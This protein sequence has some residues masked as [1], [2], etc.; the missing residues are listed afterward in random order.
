MNNS[1]NSDT[2]NYLNNDEINIISI[3]RI[4]LRS[5]KLL[6][7]S[8]FSFT[9]LIVIFSYFI[10]PVWKGSFEME[11]T[12]SINNRNLFNSSNILKS[13]SGGEISSNNKTEELV[14]KSPLVLNDVFQFHKEYLKRK[15]KNNVE[16]NL[17]F[18][19]W[20]RSFE[21]NF[22]RGTNII[23]VSFINTD[24]DHILNV[25]NLI[26]DKYEDYSL[27]DRIE[28]LEKLNDYLISQKKIVK[29]KSSESMRELNKFA[30]KHGLGNIDG[31]VAL[32]SETTAKIPRNL[33]S[34][35][36][37]Q[38]AIKNLTKNF[39][40][41]DKEISA[42]QRYA[43][44]RILLEN[45]EAEY[46]DLLA[47]LKPNASTIINL[48]KKIDNLKSRLKRPNEILIRYRELSAKAKRDEKIFFDV[49]NQLSMLKLDIARSETPWATITPPFLH[50]IRVSP[51]RKSI[52]LTAFFISLVSLSTYIIVKEKISGRIFEFDDLKN[53]LKLNH[54]LSL[55]GE[56][57]KVDINFV[58]TLI[59]NDL[60]KLSNTSYEKEQIKIITTVG[61]DDPYFK[62]VSRE[63]E[64]EIISLDTN[65]IDNADYLILMLNQNITKNEIE[66][67]NNYV[68]IYK[69]KI[70]GWIYLG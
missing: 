37:D 52:A 18:N 55:N 57:L 30:I 67:I 45:Y 11:M 29:V 33:N 8:T 53:R 68:Q 54:R 48:K 59:N 13:L 60:E 69:D 63:I 23:N 4:L 70:F 22:K 50:P 3:F 20:L 62:E 41:N 64:Y 36:F 61:L 14:L 65:K 19:N 6:L 10:K 28:K 16:K 40:S 66:K 42:G 1:S 26:K 47:V 25:L 38:N 46:N 56:D 5:K 17:V 58:K 34:D 31:F 39:G 44:Q 24:R 9:F 21:I 27:K 7:V 51:N 43:N 15:N 35:S 32:E 2:I 12:K 49:E